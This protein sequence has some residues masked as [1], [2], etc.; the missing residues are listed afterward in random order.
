MIIL[1]YKRL[2]KN[3]PKAL[4]KVSFLLTWNNISITE[5]KSSPSWDLA[6]FCLR[7][8]DK[9]TNQWTEWCDFCQLLFCSILTQLFGE[10]CPETTARPKMLRT[11]NKLSI[12]RRRIY[13]CS[14]TLHIAM[15]LH[16]GLSNEVTRP[17]CLAVTCLFSVTQGFYFGCCSFKHNLL[18]GFKCLAQE[19]QKCS[20]SQ[21]AAKRFGFGLVSVCFIHTNNML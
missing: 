17:S 18:H 9:E 19:S 3:N 16:L 15:K 20:L 2:W 5:I 11:H 21:L 4:Y 12:C 8:P 13:F 7:E 14:L 6:G 1:L 10:R